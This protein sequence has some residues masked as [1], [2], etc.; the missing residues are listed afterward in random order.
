MASTIDV[1]FIEQYNAALHVRYENA[2][3]LYR[4]M[5][6]EGTV[7]GKK[8]YWQR[9]GSFVAT[10]KDRN[11]QVT[12]QDPEHTRVEATMADKYVGSLVDDLDL[13]KQNINEMQAHANGQMTA[14]GREFDA[15]IRTTIASSSGGEIGP[16]DAVALTL[17]HM[18]DVSETFILANAPMDGNIYCAVGARTWSKMLTIPEFVNLDYVGPDQLPFASGMIAKNWRGIMWWVDPLIAFNAGTN[19][20]TNLVWHRDA[21]G[22]G[23]NKEPSTDI[24][25][26][27]LYQA[28]AFVSSM[29]QGSAVIEPN[30]A[31][32]WSV[33]TAA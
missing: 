31:Y 15:G 4:N 10:D 11:G 9:F 12:L 29:S 25:W 23:T 14:L 17:A 24:G 19:V 22:H 8:V 3:F 32:T 16:G 33:D 13:M 2:G 21:I 6:R 26:E 27:R 30:G 20:E 18:N 5:T 28:H 1:S 7:Q